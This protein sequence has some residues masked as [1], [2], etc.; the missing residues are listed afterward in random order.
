MSDTDF[1]FTD[2]S[3]GALPTDGEP[4][5]AAGSDSGDSGSGGG[6][7]I[8]PDSLGSGDSGDRASWR[9][10]RDAWDHTE[11]NPEF[12]LGPDRRTARGTFKQRKAP[13]G[14]SPDGKASSVRSEGAVTVSELEWLLRLAHTSVAGLVHAPEFELDGDDANNLAVPLHE[15]MLMNGIKPPK[16]AMAYVKL[17]LALTAVYPPRFHAYRQRRRAEAASNVTHGFRPATVVPLA[18]APNGTQPAGNGGAGTLSDDDLLNID[19]T[20]IPRKP[21]Q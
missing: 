14:G 4:A 16:G 20:N 5:S 2:D 19:P 12:H 3:G 10:R 7:A 17:L 8:S 15:I 18:P 9:E 13:A 21:L 11:Y 1:N 6:G